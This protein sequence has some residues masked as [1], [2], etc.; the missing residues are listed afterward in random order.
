MEEKVVEVSEVD[1]IEL[2]LEDLAHVGG[3]IGTSVLA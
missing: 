2:A 3:G 1:V